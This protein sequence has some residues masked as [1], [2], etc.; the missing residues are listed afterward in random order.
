M[1]NKQLEMEYDST[2]ANGLL[3]EMLK[4]IEAET[5]NVK[6]T[7]PLTEAD[8]RLGWEPSMDYVGGTWH[9][10]WKLYQLN[11]LKEHMI[12]AYRE[13]TRLRD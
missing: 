13:T 3:D 1:L 12:P 10:K 2:K 8:S 11:D 6:K 9:L 4:L 7:I 5:E